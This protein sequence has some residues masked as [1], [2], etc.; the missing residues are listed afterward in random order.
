VVFGKTDASAID[1]SA[2]G[3]G[4]FVINGECGADGGPMMRSMGGDSSGRSVASAGDVNGDGLADLIVGAPYASSSAGRSY[5]VFGTADTS[6]IELSAVAAGTAG[7]VINGQCGGDQSGK[8]VASAGDVNGDG[9]ADLIVGAPSASS[10][11]GRSYV[12]FGTSDSSTIEL[13][14]VAA[15]TGGFV[16]NGQGASDQSGI[17]VASAGDVNGDGLADLIV[18]APNASSY[19]GRSY[20]I[21][22]STTG[23]FSQ[24]AVDQLGGTGND[25]LAG[26]A[27]ADVLVGGVGHDTLTGAGGAD[28]LM[29]GA[30]DD[31]LVV[32]ASN[33]AALV[34]NFGSGGNTAQLARID[35]GGGLD[36]LRLDGGGLTL[37]LTAIANQGG[38]TPGSSSRIEGIERIDLTGSG[39]NALV[40]SYQDVLDMAGMNLINS[41]TQVALGW[42]AAAT[43]TTPYNF[44]AQE[45]RHQL[46]IDG[47]AGDTVNLADSGYWTEMGKVTHTVNTVSKT[48]DVYQYDD[49]YSQLLIDSSVTVNFSVIPF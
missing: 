4:G 21:F 49:A 46:I 29:G 47:D 23:A 19:A 27:G 16:I 39:D 41:S 32:D 13:S 42:A 10:S 31:V 20:V 38:G 40:V 24:T 34:A 17:S 45:R 30:G 26:T 37:D 2:L 12:V 6:T 1:L 5:V 44:E 18:G 35:G 48:Y 33:I 22:G 11:A 8:S 36:T 28:V 25:T 43:A 9:L 3:T 14:A 15:G 7:F